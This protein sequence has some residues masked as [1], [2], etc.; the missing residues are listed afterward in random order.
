MYG[1]RPRTLIVSKKII[2]EANRVAHLWAGVFIGRSS[3]LV[4]RPRDQV[5]MVR[6][7]LEIHWFVGVGY[8]SQGRAIASIIRGMPR[9]VGDANWS[10]KL[11]IMVKF[12]LF[13]VLSVCWGPNIGLAGCAPGLCGG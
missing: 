12:R 11:S 2:R 4:K 9:H 10:K 8:R 1:R 3:S 6:R 13:L 5:W 7:R